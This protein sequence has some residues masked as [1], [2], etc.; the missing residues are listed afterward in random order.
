M[1]RHNTTDRV[2]TTVHKEE[3]KVGQSEWRT[4]FDDSVMI[5]G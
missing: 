2:S 4:T 5:A 1:Q 3:R